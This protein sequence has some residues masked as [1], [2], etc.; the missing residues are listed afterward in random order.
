[1][2]AESIAPDRIH[3]SGNTVIDAL[4]SIKSRLHEFRAETAPIASVL[5]QCSAQRIILVTTHRRE[6]FSGGMDRIASAVRSLAER[7][8]VFVVMPV[9]P[10]PSV[11][12][13]MEATLA[14]HPR[15]ALVQPLE[16][17]PFIY[18]L[19]RCHLVLTDSGG[20]QEEAPSLG[21]PVLVMRDTTERPEGIEAGT[22]L[23]V[24]TDSRRIVQE[25]SRLLDDTAAYDRMSRAHNP[26]GDGRAARRIVNA[27]AAKHSSMLTAKAVS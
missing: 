16:Y 25:A 24:G 6:N 20:V 2:L 19:N 13:V 1:L 7:G 4:L 23:L 9:H 8:D 27:V 10:N 11:R 5:R 22:A 14:G 15:I 17:V 21:K 26:F 3:V 12:S 18:L